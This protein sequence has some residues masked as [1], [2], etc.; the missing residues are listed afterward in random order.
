MQHRLKVASAA[1]EAA[2]SAMDTKEGMMQLLQTGTTYLG[3][4]LSLGKNAAEVRLLA[5]FAFCMP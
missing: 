5:L 3:L 2:K 1:M 4:L